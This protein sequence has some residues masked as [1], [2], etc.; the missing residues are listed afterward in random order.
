MRR[1]ERTEI[2]VV[3]VRAVG[4][5]GQRVRLVAQVHAEPALQATR[6]EERVD[7]LGGRARDD[8]WRVD[9]YGGIQQVSPQRAEAPT[10]CTML[11]RRFAV[12]RNQC[13]PIV[14]PSTLAICYCVRAKPGV[15]ALSRM[16]ST[17]AS[18]RTASGNVARAADAGHVDRKIPWHRGHGST[19]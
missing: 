16:P 5:D 14:W 1:M 18:K 15:V 3:A 6:A 7:L 9:G 2:A 12:D 13:R 11:L 17:P 4:L 8:A 10:S 19:R